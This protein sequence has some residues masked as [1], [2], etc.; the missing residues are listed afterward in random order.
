MPVFFIDMVMAI[1]VGI[2][3]SSDTIVFI[4]NAQKLGDGSDISRHVVS[5]AKCG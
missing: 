1:K 2:L 3:A 5:N 4:D